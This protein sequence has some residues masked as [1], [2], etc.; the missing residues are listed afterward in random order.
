[1]RL[2]NFFVILTL[3]TL[4]VSCSSVRATSSVDGQISK[5]CTTEASDLEIFR[6]SLDSLKPSSTVLIRRETSP[7]KLELDWLIGKRG[8]GSATEAE[9]LL[10]ELIAAY[11][12]RNETSVSLNLDS[13]DRVKIITKS[14]LDVFFAN[15]GTEGYTRLWKE[16]P[17]ASAL[18]SLSLPGYSLDR[19][20]ALLY[21]NIG[22]GP[23]DVQGKVLI[24]RKLSRQWVVVR[25]FIIAVS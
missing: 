14:E 6:A 23:F 13:L 4:S 1:M 21:V 20:L 11:R 12:Q 10:P 18:A 17:D 19:S 3:G 9:P 8:A 15:G 16:F 2:I 25:T 24:L 22:R 7:P 5:C